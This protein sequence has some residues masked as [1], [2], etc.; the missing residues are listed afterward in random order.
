MEIFT[1]ADA[2]TV[3]TTLVSY[4]TDNAPFLIAL[5]AGSAGLGFVVRQ[6]KKFTHVRG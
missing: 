5:L 6:I 4:V 3:L 1:A 2:A